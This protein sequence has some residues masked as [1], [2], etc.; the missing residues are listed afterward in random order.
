MFAV[1][2]DQQSQRISISLDRL[3]YMSSIFGFRFAV[4]VR[5]PR[6]S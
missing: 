3:S 2:T 4:H 6:S 5:S 1:A